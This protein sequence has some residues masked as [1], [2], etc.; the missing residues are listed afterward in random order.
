MRIRIWAFGFWLWTGVA[1][2]QAQSL[3][4]DSYIVTFKQPG[5]ARQG[6][7]VA[8]FAPR[9]LS[10]MQAASTLSD[11][12]ASSLRSQLKISGSVRS[13]YDRINA[14][15]LNISATEAQKLQSDPRVLRVEQNRTV[16]LV[17]TQMNPGWALDRID[18][19]YTWPN[20][21]YNYAFDGTGR[22]VYVLDSGLNLAHPTVAA[23]F[24]G[25][26]QII[27]D[28][29]GGNGSDC[30]FHGTA[31]AAAAAGKTYGVAKNAKLMIAKI[32]S[33]CTDSTDTAVLTMALNWLAGNAPRGSIVNLSVG[34][35]S[36]A[37]YTNYA[38]ESAIKAA[39]DAGI[40]VVMAAGNAS[41]DTSA[42]SFT[43]LS[44]AFVIGATSEKYLTSL[45]KDAMATFTGHGGNIAGFAPGVRVLLLNHNGQKILADGT[46]FAA[47]YVAGLFAAGCQAAGTLCN[48]MGSASVA[49]QALKDKAVNGSIVTDAG[50]SNLPSATP[51]RFFVRN[52]W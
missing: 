43:R 20:N 39:H 11:S 38:M 35:E 36:C 31:V 18:Q 7:S 3:I 9:A 50:A 13:V 46:S 52:A 19:A 28:V 15:H 30:Y 4:S 21:Q 25:R 51:S 42:N 24:G 37:P 48:T 2:A 26:A 32:T 8:A 40:I 22:T 45:Q 34:L 33:G 44:Q 47:P 17:G 10:Q 12:T 41:C 14:V 5:V 6:F 29:N 49:Y 23:E 27:Y 1:I 16:S